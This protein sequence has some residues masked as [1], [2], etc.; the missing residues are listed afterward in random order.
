MA[1]SP[2]RSPLGAYLSM[3]GLAVAVFVGLNLIAE[4]APRGSGPSP[5]SL[6]P[7]VPGTPSVER[8]FMTAV[9]GRPRVSTA[10][11]YCDPAGCCPTHR[12]TFGTTAPTK[13]VIE[14]FTVQGYSAL[15]GD[16]DVVRPGPFPA[17]RW[18]AELDYAG[19]WAWRRVEVARGTDVDRPD[20]PT[21][22]VESSIACGER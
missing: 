12:T 16:R 22:F 19:R 7:L 15:P 17:V 2:G 4:P 5:A 9:L 1:A 18:T 6:A 14:A 20:W 11:P 13:D 3:A 10:R 8:D 21:V